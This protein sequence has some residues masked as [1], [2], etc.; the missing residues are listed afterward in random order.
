MD[1]D[2]WLKFIDEDLWEELFGCVYERFVLN[3]FNV[4]VCDCV[5]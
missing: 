5:N 2:F 1:E 3:C 4:D